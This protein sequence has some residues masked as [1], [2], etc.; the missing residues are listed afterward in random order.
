MSI[1][2]LFSNRGTWVVIAVLILAVIITAYIVYSKREGMDNHASMIS[3]GEYGLNRG[4]F[5]PSEPVRIQGMSAP[6]NQIY[7]IVSLRDGG[8]LEST[9]NN[10]RHGYGGEGMSD[11]KDGSQPMRLKDTKMMQNMGFAYDQ[12]IVQD[13]I[14]GRGG[15]VT[16]DVQSA[17]M[18]AAEGF[19][20][21]FDDNAMDPVLGES[22]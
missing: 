10:K 1:G 3:E 12:L 18:K 4:N 8:N 2:S 15:E 13:K 22:M 16:R 7:Q 21:G 19:S 20:E 6:D 14:K 5:L 9:L 17:Y 11:M